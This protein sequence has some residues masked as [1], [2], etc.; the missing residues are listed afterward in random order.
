MSA[1]ELTETELTEVFREIIAGS[2]VKRSRHDLVSGG[3]DRTELFLR[4]LVESGYHPLTVDAVRITPGQRTPAFL[5]REGTALFGWVFWEKFSQLRLRK[6]FGTVVRKPNGDWFVQ[7]PAA[8][9]AI[10]YADPTQIL[11]MDID[12]PF[13][14]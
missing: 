9:S 3:V 5:V 8:G 11:P 4:T 12:R 13:E 7:L 2:S 6:L 10:I 1:H 14:L